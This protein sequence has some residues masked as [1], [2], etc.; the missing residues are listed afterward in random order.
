MFHQP[1]EALP[2]GNEEAEQAGPEGKTLSANIKSKDPPNQLDQVV[3]PM[4]DAKRDGDKIA[5]HMVEYLGK[6]D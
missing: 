2:L 5:V 1:T 3:P 6:T 4:H